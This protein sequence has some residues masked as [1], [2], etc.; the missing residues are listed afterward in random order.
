MS[1]N[2][3][4]RSFLR[5]LG[6]LGCFTLSPTR[7][8][9]HKVKTEPTSK[10][11]NEP[12]K[13]LSGWNTIDD[14]SGGFHTGQLIGIDGT[15]G[16]GLELVIDHLFFKVLEKAGALLSDVVLTCPFK[17]YHFVCTNFYA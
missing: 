5:N 13:L 3:N 9:E 1:S 17:R 11:N 2:Y 14:F 7:Q 12:E 15:P 16:K 4:R 6:Y 10:L 8:L